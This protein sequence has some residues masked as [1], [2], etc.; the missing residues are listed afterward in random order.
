[1]NEEREPPIA[2]QADVGAGHADRR[3]GR[4]LPALKQD[5]IDNVH[6]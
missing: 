3:H 1:V 4:L 2:D 6:G 5:R